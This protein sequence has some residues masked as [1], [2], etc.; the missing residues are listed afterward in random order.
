MPSAPRTTISGEIEMQTYARLQA[1][2]A[3]M[4]ERGASAVEYGLL[5]AGVAAVIVLVVFALGG[6]VQDLFDD[7]GSCI[8]TEGQC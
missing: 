8:S 6:Q 3:T 4:G 7:T 5:L 1:R 2:L